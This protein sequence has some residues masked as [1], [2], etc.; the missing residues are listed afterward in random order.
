MD[1]DRNAILASLRAHE[2]ELRRAGVLSLSLFGSAARG[3]AGPKSDID[4]VVRLS[5]DFAEGGFEYLGRL[6]DLRERLGQIVGREVDIVTEPIRKDRLR[7]NCRGGSA[8]CLLSSREIASETSSTISPGSNLT[9]EISPK[10]SFVG[11]RRTQDAVMYCLLLISEA[12]VKL[13]DQIDALAP[14]EP[15]D[16]IRS[17][18]NVLRHGYDEIDLRVIWR[19]ARNDLPSLRAAC[20]RALTALPGS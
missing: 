11:D 18:G 1:R 2:S 17:L 10:G 5:E 8:T 7:R 15:W 3:D 12:A 19:I 4:I 14:G 13:Q 9:S 16:K 6:E 20:E